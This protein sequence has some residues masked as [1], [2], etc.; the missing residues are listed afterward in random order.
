MTMSRTI[1]TP[2][3]PIG[4]AVITLVSSSMAF[5]QV[6]RS[7]PPAPG[8]APTVNIGQHKTFLLPNGMRV[9]VVENHK[10][11]LVSVQ[12]KFDI[13]PILQGDKTGYIDLMGDLLASGTAQRTKQQIDEEVDLLGASL[14]ASSDG[15]YAE[16]LKKNLPRVLTLVADLVTSPAFPEAELE[17]A[18]TRMISSVESRKDDPDGIADVVGRVLTF[19]KGHPY[20]EVV[21]TETLEKVDRKVINAYYAHFFRPEKGYV[22]LVGDITEK[23][24]REQLSKELGGWK[25]HTVPTSTNEQGDEVVDG[26][27]VVR[28]PRK[29][30]QPH[31]VRRVTIVDRPGSPQSVI[32]ALFPVDLKPNDPRLPAAQVMNTILG[33][34]TFSARL[35]QNLREDKGYTYGAYSSLD[36]DRWCGSFSAGASV[37]TEVTDSA[38]TDMMVE[39][40]HLGINGVRK[41]ELDL[42]KSFMAGGF[43]RSLEDPR[44]VARFALNTY[45]YDLPKDHYA[46]YLKRLEAVTESDVVKAA[47]DLLK[48]DNA[49][50]LVVGDKEVLQNRL[51]NVSYDQSLTQFDHNGDP[52]REMLDPAPAGVTAKTVLDTYIKAIGGTKAL[53]G[54]K[55]LKKVM[56]TSVMGMPV[57]MTQYN[58]VPDKYFME[59]SA[60]GTVLQKVVLDG[61]KARSSGMAG[62]QEIIENELEDLIQ[63]AAPFPELHYEKYG[64]KVVLGGVANIGESKVYKL[65]FLTENGGMFKEYFDVESGLKLRREETASTPEGTFTTITDYKDHREVK[66][67]KFP[68]LIVQKGAMDMNLVVTEVVVNGGVRATQFAVD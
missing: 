9:I 40:E 20:G 19:S 53:E 64:H 12:V 23:E 2:W 66:G 44:T 1:A 33:G 31:K 67:I 27:G 45:L 26:L 22:V 48:P 49:A 28:R 41:S 37:R 17:K 16:C 58:A 46:T 61:K 68:F 50:I 52:F 6:D 21:T 3:R 36:A 59:M 4:L 65:T 43:A 38:I 57:T 56:T 25:G 10:L 47:N 15:V 14:F 60:G 63:Q 11:P 5:A 35:M 55:D 24:A 39:I 34:G 8:P 30:P 13:D 29:T 18:R 42:A 7:R 62:E 54:V 51:R 32:K